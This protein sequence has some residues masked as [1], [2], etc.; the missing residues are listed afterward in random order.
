MKNELPL[1]HFTAWLR[2]DP[3]EGRFY[4][5]ARPANCT[6]IGDRAGCLHNSGYR[7][8]KLKFVSY[9]EHRLVWLFETGSWPS[10]QIDHINGI[11]D[12]NRFI[13]LREAT[14]RENHQNEP[15]HRS[16]N[17]PGATFRDDFQDW[18]ARISVD[19]R[20]FYLGLHDTEEQAHAVYME[21]ATA[22]CIETAINEVR[23]RLGIGAN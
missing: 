1:E 9:K 8:I 20:T 23:E 10:D 22:K 15:V 19:G 17:L 5:A 21:V 6:K 12:E 4:W 11:K 7:R 3:V 18:R 14:N 13:N 2:Y 16:G